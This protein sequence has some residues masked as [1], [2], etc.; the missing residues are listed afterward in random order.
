[1]SHEDDEDDVQKIELTIIH[2]EAVPDVWTRLGLW[3]DEEDDD[4]DELEC[5][6]VVSDRVPAIQKFRKDIF[7][8]G[9][10]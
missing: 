2:K 5:P 10:I 1:M 7:E 3:P 8:R 6:P 4:E 9:V